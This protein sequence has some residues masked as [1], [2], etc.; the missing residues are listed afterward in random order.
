VRLILA[1]NHLGLGGSE[2]YLLTVAEQFERL[3]HEATIYGQELGAGAK[4]ARSRGIR[5]VDESRLP[6]DCDGVLAQDAAVSLDLASRY[7]RARQVFVAHSELFDLQL[8][9]QLEGLVDCLVALNDRV[10]DRLRALAVPVRVVRLRQPIDTERFVAGPPLPQRPRRALL[11]SNNP[12]ADRLAML[13]A[14]CAEAGLELTRVGGDAGQSSDP[15]SRLAEADIVIGYGRT[16]LEAMACARAAYVY[17]RHGCD[18][19]VT[20]DSYAEIEAGGFAGRTGRTVADREALRDDLARFDPEM[21]PVNHDLVLAHHRANVHAQQLLEL[22]GDGGEKAASSHGGLEEMARLVRA[23]W[24]ARVDAQAL[25]AEQTRLQGE[26]H[27]LEQRLVEVREETKA[28]TA[29]AFQDT[30]SWRLT[31]P[32]RALGRLR[33]VFREER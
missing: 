20:P 10:A 11:L 26:R 19:W 28:Q 31:K 16:V 30:L 15:R 17:D 8:P 25:V 33:T 14:A 23:E 12:V 4:L 7:P 22:I 2:S 1:S 6:A 27:L 24:R 18:G 13:E 29:A 32:V 21:G 9:P 3:G 5:V